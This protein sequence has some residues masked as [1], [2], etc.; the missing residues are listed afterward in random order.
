MIEEVGGPACAGPDGPNRGDCAAW[1]LIPW[2]VN[3]TLEGEER[4]LVEREAAR[5]AACAAEIATQRRVADAVAE[6]SSLDEIE[7]RSWARLSERLA[8]ERSGG[9]RSGGERSGGDPA[10]EAEPETNVVPLQ[11]RAT[12]RT[13]VRHRLRPL[14]LAVPA[15]VAAGLAAVVIWPAL[16]GGPAPAPGEPGYSTLTSGGE[17]GATEL[18]LRLDDSAAGMDL[19]AIADGLGLDLAEGPS[20]GQVYRLT[21]RPGTNPERAAA[22]LRAVPGVALVSLGAER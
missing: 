8:A 19:S 7:D 21:P 4:A 12:R 18:R 16:L 15:L 11:P 5:C 22:A 6:L 1:A 3:G 9:E 10:P 14:A 2:Y 17:T 20:A 13:E